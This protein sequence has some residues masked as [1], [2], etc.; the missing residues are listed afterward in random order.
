MV[1]KFDK[2]GR[3][4]QEPWMYT[5]GIFKRHIRN[6]PRAWRNIGLTKLNAH[7]MYSNE[8]I[9]QSQQD[10]WNGQQKPQSGEDLYI[11]DMLLDW[12]SQVFTIFEMLLQVQQFLSGMKWTFVIDGKQSTKTVSIQLPIMVV[13]GDMPFLNKLVQFRGGLS[14]Q[15]NACHLCN[16][17]LDKC[18]D[19][20]EQYDVTSSHRLIHE[21]ATNPAAMK[22]VGYYPLKNNIFH[23]LE[24]C[25]KRGINA[26]TPVEPL[27]CV[28]LGLFIRLLQGFNRL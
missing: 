3:I 4:C 9:R 1:C 20:Y 27:H 8:E 10:M 13:M 16:I 18:D 12:H 6:Q 15:S 7:N 26:S 28:L 23:Q 25:H 24:F 11:S 19:P 14:L 5:L 17:I 22:Q 2:N 21:I